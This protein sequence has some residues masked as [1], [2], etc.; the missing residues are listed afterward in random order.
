MD[1]FLDTKM[2]IERINVFL[3]F[4]K[5]ASAWDKTLNSLFHTGY[6]MQY[7]N[8]A[9]RDL[10]MNICVYECVHTH[11]CKSITPQ[12]DK[13][14][15]SKSYSG[16][17]STSSLGRKL[18]W[19]NPDDWRSTKWKITI[20]LCVHF[21]NGSHFWSA[22]FSETDETQICPNTSDASVAPPFPSV[23]K[24]FPYL[25]FLPSFHKICEMHLFS[26]VPKWTSLQF[27]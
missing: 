26:S 4:I 10:E 19:K 5:P 11:A 18:R 1:G 3:T 7:L 9:S 15:I 20:H 24:E 2:D 21:V 22:N 8:K 14:S 13:A 25:C 16:W 17:L 12:F 27:I 23:Y 6:H